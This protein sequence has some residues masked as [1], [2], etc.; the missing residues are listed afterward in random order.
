M[1]G[2]QV[3]A[4]AC[5]DPHAAV[6]VFRKLGE[7]EAREGGAAGVPKFLRTHPVSTERIAAIEA[8]LGTAEGLYELQG[9]E[10]ARGPLKRF[11]AALRGW[12]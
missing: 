2:V 8:M 11:R 12:G 9:C 6:S 1:I 4:R 7:A 10:A 3:M 5:Y